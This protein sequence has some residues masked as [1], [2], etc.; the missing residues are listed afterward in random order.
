[1]SEMKRVLLRAVGGPTRLI[2]AWRQHGLF[3]SDAFLHGLIEHT[4]FAHYQL[5]D[6]GK[7]WL[8]ERGIRL[9][10]QAKAQ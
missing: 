4:D 10:F 5:T 8:A 7:R 1:M 6:A 2:N 9:D 3:V